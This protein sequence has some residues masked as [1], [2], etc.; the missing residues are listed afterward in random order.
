MAYVNFR[1][2]E[3]VNHQ[4]HSMNVGPGVVTAERKVQPISP[5]AMTT[6]S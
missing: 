1:I 6:C 5:T 4:P 2:W 3:S